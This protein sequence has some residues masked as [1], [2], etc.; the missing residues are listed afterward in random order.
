[1]DSVNSSHAQQK[2]LIKQLEEQI[3][4][5]NLELSNSEDS[6]SELKADLEDANQKIIQLEEDLYESKQIQLELLDKLN[7][8]TKEFEAYV[9]E[10]DGKADEVR[11]EYQHKLGY[12]QQKIRELHDICS[13]LE[14]TQVIYIAHKNDK[15]DIALA[16]FIN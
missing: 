3:E 10:N 5:L 1:M 15:T 9:Q 12:A 2:V 6:R 4:Q 11:A 7:Q 8:T 13:Q 16:N 14:H